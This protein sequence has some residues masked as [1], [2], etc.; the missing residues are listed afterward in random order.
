MV[1]SSRRSAASLLSALVLISACA[2]KDP[3]RVSDDGYQSP[4]PDGLTPTC[5][6]YIGKKMRCYC[7]TRDGLR[8][9]LDPENY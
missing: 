1:V 2:S 7:G 5:Y 6:E 4:C 3:Y 8:E 9:I